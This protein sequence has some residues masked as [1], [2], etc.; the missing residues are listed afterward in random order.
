M[1]FTLHKSAPDVEEEKKRFDKHPVMTQDGAVCS[2]YLLLCSHQSSSEVAFLFA[3][4]ETC[5]PIPVPDG[6]CFP[7]MIH[8][9]G[10][11][12]RLADVKLVCIHVILA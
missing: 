4:S 8:L 9:A 3:P 1:Y 12:F 10:W 6:M 11:V 5:F 7:W 2:G